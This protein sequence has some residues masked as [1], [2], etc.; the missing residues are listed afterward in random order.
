MGHRNVRI[1]MYSHDTFGLGHLRRCRTIAHALVENISSLHILIISGSPIAGAFD[2][3][4]RV[5]FVKIPS[6][7][8]LHSGEYKSMVEHIDLDETM[9]M[10]RSMIRDTARSF[11]PDIMIVDKEPMGLHD[12]LEDT[13]YELKNAGAILILGLRDV[14]DSDRLLKQEWRPKNM[15]ARIDSVYDHIWVYGPESFWNPLDGLKIPGHM[16]ARLIYTGFLRRTVPTSAYRHLPTQDDFI[17]ITTGGGGDGAE[18]LKNA[19]AAYEYDESI[20]YGAV[21]VLGPFMPAS[22]R[23]EIFDRAEKIGRITV[24]E[25]DA[26][27]EKLIVDA[28]AVVGMCGYNTFCEYLSFDKRTLYVPRVRPREEQLVRATRAAELGLAKVLTPENASDP[29]IMSGALHELIK[30]DVPSSA[31]QKGM[32]NGLDT[33]VDAVREIIHKSDAPE[34]SVVKGGIS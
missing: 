23:D 28:K 26:L 11:E 24:I 30:A 13:L 31:G 21:M 27:I 8:K 25:F 6:V 17:L 3:R 20:P 7:I 32:M 2:F 4:V 15:V 19:L 12:E 33:I 9:E 29:A 22:D 34:L 5:D 10:R 14:M 18:L 16:Q 1:L